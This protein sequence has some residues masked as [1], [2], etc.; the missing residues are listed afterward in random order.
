MARILASS[1]T[2]NREG[3]IQ[4]LKTGGM[5]LGMR[6]GVEYDEEQFSIAINIASLTGLLE[7]NS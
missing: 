1:A 4:I 3:E 6:A 5:P 7:D 2:I